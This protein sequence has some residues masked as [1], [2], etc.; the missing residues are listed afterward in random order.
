MP[1]ERRYPPKPQ[2]W[3]DKDWRAAVDKSYADQVRQAQAQQPKAAQQAKPTS[4]APPPLPKEATGPQVVKV[5]VGFKEAYADTMVL[6]CSDGRFTNAVQ[7]LLT[8]NGCP[9]YDI[10]ALAGGP[11]LLDMTNASMVEVEAMRGSTSFL[12]K[13]HGIKKVYLVAHEGCGFYKRRYGGQSN[14]WLRDRQVRDLQVAAAW[15]KKTHPKVE[16]LL[17]MAIPSTTGGT[18]QFFPV[19]PGDLSKI[20]M[21][22]I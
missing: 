16:A 17:Y 5:D 15:F 21:V 2:G 22:L 18:V 14:A 10:M 13:G 3:S 7:G 12:V 11:A 20:M 19:E 1:Q 4:V 8:A 9:N 6:H